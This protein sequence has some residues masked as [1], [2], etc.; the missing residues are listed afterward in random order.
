MRRGSKAGRALLW[1]I[2]ALAPQ[3]AR[4][5]VLGK[6]AQPSDSGLT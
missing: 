2:L 6:P 1:A 4:G 5:D 3:G